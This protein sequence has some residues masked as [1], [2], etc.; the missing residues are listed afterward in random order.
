MDSSFTLLGLVAIV[1]MLVTLLTYTP[2]EGFL[3]NKD[4]LSILDSL[5]GEQVSKAQML[6][7]PDLFKITNDSLE[8]KMPIK[9]ERE[10]RVVGK[11]C[12]V[13]GYTQSGK[14]T[15]GIGLNSK[16][17]DQSQLRV[18][19]NTNKGAVPLKYYV[20]SEDGAENTIGELA[21]HRFRYRT[22]HNS[23]IPGY[24]KNYN[25]P[26]IGIVQF[27][28]RQEALY[29]CDA[30]PY[31]Q[32]VTYNKKL[33][34]YTLRGN[35]TRIHNGMRIRTIKHPAESSYTKIV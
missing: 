21:G 4:A 10:L 14:K 18:I 16:N 22:H 28:D 20:I 7:D 34:T 3:S 33:R 9:I 32:G 23:Y 27:K 11:D 8:I 12:K 15:V 6:N 26:I 17:A 2:S 30:H 25:H 24:P 31:C 29:A 35:D 1:S 19:A 13:E 5:K